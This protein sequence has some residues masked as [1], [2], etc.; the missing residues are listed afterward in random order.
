MW[1][2]FFLTDEAVGPGVPGAAGA[3]GAQGLSGMKTGRGVPGNKRRRTN[4]TVPA[5][6]EA[7]EG[8]V[9][10]FTLCEVNSPSD[11]MKVLDD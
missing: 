6:S 1:S 2:T 3:G 11:C 9:T 7:Q 4:S 10:A 5:I 8:K